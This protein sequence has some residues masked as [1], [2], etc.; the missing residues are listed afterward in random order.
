MTFSFQI[1]VIIK[2]E[3]WTTGK[4]NMNYFNQLL[5]KKIFKIEQTI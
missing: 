3:V 2:G 4:N 1:F 5:L